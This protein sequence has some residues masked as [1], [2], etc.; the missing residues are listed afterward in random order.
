MARRKGRR[1]GGSGGI[2]ALL[3]PFAA[4]AIAGA[5]GPQIPVVNSL[6]ALGQGAIGGYLVKRS[7]MGAVAGAAGAQL[8][9]PL[10]SSVIGGSGT[11]SKQGTW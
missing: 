6:P 4:G 3:K 8:A 9:T 2:M 1:S 5:I 11:A 10:I 7:V